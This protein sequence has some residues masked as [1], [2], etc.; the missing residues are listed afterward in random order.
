MSRTFLCLVK[1]QSFFTTRL[2]IGF[3]DVCG[4][5]DDSSPLSA[6][7]YV[8]S[9]SMRA[10]SYINLDGVVTGVCCWAVWP[11]NSRMAE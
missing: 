9:L 4:R 3:R 8:S 6:Q 2:N 11:L 7:G 1:I 10:F 5:D